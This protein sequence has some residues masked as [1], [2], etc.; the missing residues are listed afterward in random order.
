M[1][2]RNRKKL[3]GR[4]IL[5]V[6]I[7]LVLVYIV[8]LFVTTNFLGSNNIVT[9]TAYKTTAYEAIKTTA[10]VVRDEEYLSSDTDG[11]MVYQASD[12]DKVT[13]DGEI[14]RVYSNEEDVVNMQR[15]E[16]LNEKIEYLETLNS[17]S[18]SVNVGI[19][20]VNSQINEKL[21]NLRKAVNAKT[22]DYI[23]DVTDD[24]MSVIY[25]KQI[26]TGEQK[27][28][29]EAIE[30]LT[31]E[32]NELESHTPT[33]VGVVKTPDSGYFVSSVDGYEN[34]VSF[35]DID[36]VSYAD[37]KAVQPQDIDEDAYVGKVIKGVAWYLLCPISYDD[38]VNISHNSSE[39]KVR[40]PYATGADIPAKVRYVKQFADE[41]QV[42]LVLECNFM[43]D[44]LSKIRNES[45][46]I[47]I[48]EYEGLMVP[49]SAIHDDY[50]ERENDDGTVTKEK[51]QGVYV[52]YGNEL[53]FRQ[54]SILY[55]GDTYVI[56]DENP[57]P[58]SLI[59]GRS[60]ALYD[61]VVIE[62]SDLFNG[63]LIE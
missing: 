38:S 13:V 50:L 32:K 63:K 57:D 40:L 9:E 34:A 30:E 37:Y 42:M 2:N 15:I 10:L 23:A 49:K 43:N 22:F 29:T 25:Q 8:F 55:S 14:A 11:I 5:G 35:A 19:D 4:I 53:I 18:A 20:T 51:V 1:K 62:G 6:V 27:N 3:T 47:V 52:N 33:P 61:Q 60:I 16:E 36:E 59:E 7:T 45:V 48:N 12:G 28:F 26:I 41:E 44:A 46:E 56:C 39:V 58:E 54:I 17:F 24:L 21:V 31:A